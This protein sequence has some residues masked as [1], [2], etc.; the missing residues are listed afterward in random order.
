MKYVIAAPIKAPIMGPNTVMN[1]AYGAKSERFIRTSPVVC[2]QDCARKGLCGI[3]HCVGLSTSGLTA[4]SEV[5][6]TLMIA[7][8]LLKE[9]K[10]RHKL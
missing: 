2:P 10:K 5:S 6:V 7:R 9:L 4:P 3:S 8:Q 1:G